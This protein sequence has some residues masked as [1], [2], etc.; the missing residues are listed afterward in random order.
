MLSGFVFLQLESCM[1]AGEAMDVQLSLLSW[2]PGI[3][4]FLVL[5]TSAA[6]PQVFAGTVSWRGLEGVLPPLVED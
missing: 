5:T 2:Q 6:Q 1:G 3:R 4:N